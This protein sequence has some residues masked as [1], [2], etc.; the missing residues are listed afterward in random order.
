M[1]LPSIS[2]RSISSAPASTA[3][4][5]EVRGVAGPRR[6]RAKAGHHRCQCERRGSCSS[7]R[8]PELSR[9]LLHRDSYLRCSAADLP[10]CSQPIRARTPMSSRP[11]PRS[12]PTT[13]SPAR[14]DRSPSAF[15]ARASTSSAPPSFNIDSNSGM[16]RAGMP[17]FMSCRSCSA[18]PIWSTPWRRQGRVHAGRSRAVARDAALLDQFRQDLGSLGWGRRYRCAG[19]CPPSGARAC[20]GS[21]RRFPQARRPPSARCGMTWDIRSGIEPGCGTG[22]SAVA[23]PIAQDE[24]L[25]EVR[26]IAGRPAVLAEGEVQAWFANFRQ[27]QPEATS[28]QSLLD[29]EERARADRFVFARHRERFVRAHG[30]LR[31]VLAPLCGRPPSALSFTVGPYG[32]P[33]LADARGLSFSLSHSGDGVAIAV[34]RGVAVGIDIEERRGMEGIAMRWLR[35]SSPPRRSPRTAAPR[36]PSERTHFF[37]CGPARKPS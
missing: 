12:L 5:C 33:E 16:R 20:C 24:I 10:M 32:K 26:C 17:Y 19:R 14:P 3:C 31:L 35:V 2:P 22:W 23:A 8:S 4:M 29:A 30:M 37:S 9:A 15:R 21:I 13:Y 7:R 25:A 6:C 28:F 36:R 34:A 1:L 11:A 27:G 18:M